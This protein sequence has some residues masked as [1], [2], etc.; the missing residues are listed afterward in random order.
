MVVVAEEDR[1]TH[2]GQAREMNRP[3]IV[4]VDQRPAQ[5]R[6][7]SEYPND[8]REFVTSSLV[9]FEGFIDRL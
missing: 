8:D 5:Q 1:R 4:V 3:V 2:E 9:S 7:L 6:R